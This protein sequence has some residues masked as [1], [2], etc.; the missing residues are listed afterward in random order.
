MMAGI[1]ENGV[2]YNDKVLVELPT[3]GESNESPTFVRYVTSSMR[4]TIPSDIR[5]EYGIGRS[6]ELTIKV[7]PLGDSWES[8]DPMDNRGGNRRNVNVSE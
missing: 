2:G 1:Q 6:D 4:V 3:L 8:D 7:T 5:H